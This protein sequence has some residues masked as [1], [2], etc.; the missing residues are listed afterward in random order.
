VAQPVAGERVSRTSE[1]VQSGYQNQEEDG[2]HANREVR[3]ESALHGIP[4]EEYRI[5]A[6]GEYLT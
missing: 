6:S 4:S 2:R 3:P 5:S 1:S